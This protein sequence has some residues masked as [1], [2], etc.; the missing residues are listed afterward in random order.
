[1]K[2]TNVLHLLSGASFVAF[3]GIAQAWTIKDLTVD[4]GV[5]FIGASIN[6]AGR[7]AGTGEFG[8][9]ERAF[10]LRDGTYTML[11]AIAGKNH[12]RSTGNDINNRGQVVGYSLFRHSRTTAAYMYDGRKTVDLA[13]GAAEVP[14]GSVAHSLN[15][16]GQVVGQATYFHNGS[17]LATRAFLYSNGTM[18]QIGTLEDKALSTHASYA[19]GINNTGLVVGYSTIGPENARRWHA[20]TYANGTMTSIGTPPGYENS[21]ARAVNNSGQIVGYGQN[22]NGPT[23]AFL[24]SHG[25]MMD[26]GAVGGINSSAAYDINSKGQVVGGSWQNDLAFLYDNGH[27]IDLNSLPEVK[28]SGWTLTGALSINDRGQIVGTGIKDGQKRSFL[29]TPKRAR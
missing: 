11:D 26:I 8:G 28:A 9:T 10:I 7:I 25:S 5:K 27:F 18:V 17:W 14:Y 19:M 23:S 15:E 24:Y 16:S 20:F 12:D 21:F 22:G 6:N 4:S 13:E 2:M 3:S 29:L 1:M